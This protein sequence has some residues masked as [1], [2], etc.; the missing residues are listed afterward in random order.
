MGSFNSLAENGSTPEALEVIQL[1]SSATLLIRLESVALVRGGSTDDSL[2][3]WTTEGCVCLQ[4]FD[5]GH[6]DQREA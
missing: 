3:I 4:E 2:L 1:T 6:L 5:V